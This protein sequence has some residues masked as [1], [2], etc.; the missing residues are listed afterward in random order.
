MF[1][2]LSCLSYMYTLYPVLVS[3]KSIPVFQRLSQRHMY[4]ILFLPVFMHMFL[5]LA[6]C[7]LSCSCPCKVSSHVSHVPCN[8]VLHCV[9]SVLHMF[10]MVAYMYAI[11]CQVCSHMSQNSKGCVWHHWHTHPSACSCVNR[12]VSVCS[13]PCYVVSTIFS[14]SPT[15]L[16]P[17]ITSIL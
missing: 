1:Q 8:P 10:L 16:W 12:L 6:L 14:L 13:Y 2:M 4:C 5:T 17:I 3:V 15:L 9:K 11:L 7:T